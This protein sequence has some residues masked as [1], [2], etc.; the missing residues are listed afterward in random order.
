MKGGACKKFDGRG[1]VLRRAEASR[2]ARIHHLTH[3]VTVRAARFCSPLKCRDDPWRNGIH[4]GGSL[5]PGYR[6]GPL[7]ELVGPLCEPARSPRIGDSLRSR[8]GEGEQFRVR[9]VASTSFEIGVGG[10]VPT[11]R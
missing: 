9:V 2:G 8:F 1:D 4:P 5:T 10:G 3:V 7:P 11:S 6:R